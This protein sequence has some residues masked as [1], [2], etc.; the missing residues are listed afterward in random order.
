MVEP[1]PQP[2][3]RRRER[4]ADG[5][6]AGESKPIWFT[7]LG[8]PAVDKGTNQPNVFYDPKSA[9]SFLPYFSRGWRDDLIQR[10]FLEA[11]L[12]YW[13]DPANNPMSERLLP[14]G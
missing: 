1:A 5:V 8:C 7:E 12:G 9:E 13:A 4:R 3:G 11:A 2:A 14:A 6:G 10:R